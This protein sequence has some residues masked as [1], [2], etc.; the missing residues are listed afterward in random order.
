MTKTERISTFEVA[1]RG[2]WGLHSYELIFPP[3]SWPALPIPLFPE[4]FVFVTI[5]RD[6]SAES[7]ALSEKSFVLVSIGGRSQTK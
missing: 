3:T 4:N 2:P 5:K 1:G 6:A 7:K